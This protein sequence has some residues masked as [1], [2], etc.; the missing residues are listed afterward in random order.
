M[1]KEIKLF[2]NKDCLSSHSIEMSNLDLVIGLCMLMWDIFRLF[3]PGHAQKQC[4]WD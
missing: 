2:V 4:M 3:W 1:H